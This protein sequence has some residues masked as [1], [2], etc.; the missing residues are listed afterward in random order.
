[1]LLTSVV[2]VMIDTYNYFIIPMRKLSYSFI[3]SLIA[4]VISFNQLDCCFLV[5]FVIC[6]EYKAY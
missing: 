5:S 2:Y 6:K 1:M 3:Y 4:C